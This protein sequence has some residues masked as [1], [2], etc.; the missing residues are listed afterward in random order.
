MINNLYI[1]LNV[2]LRFSNNMISVFVFFPDRIIPI[3]FFNVPGSIHDSET[4]H[5]GWIYYKLDD[6]H[7]STGGKSTVDYAFRKV[8]HPFLA[9]SLHNI[10]VSSAP[11]T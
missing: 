8:N 2:D 7:R 3:A 1:N 4:A 5:W 10:L 11:T 6:V 9:K